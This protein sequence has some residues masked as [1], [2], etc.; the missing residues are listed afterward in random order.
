MASNNHSVERAAAA[1]TGRL[2]EFAAKVARYSV[3]AGSE[4][5]QAKNVSGVRGGGLAF[6]TRSDSLTVFARDEAYGSTREAGSYTG[7]DRLLVSRLRGTLRAAG[8]PLK[9]VASIAIQDEFGREAERIADGRLRLE[10]TRLLTRV[11]VARRALERIP[12]W[13]STAT[14]GLTKRRT[15][16]ELQIHWPE[17]PKVLLREAQLLSEFVAEGWQPPAQ[18]GAWPESLEAGLVHSPAI[19]FFLDMYA[20]IRVVYMAE[21][22]S[23]RRK[24]V[25]HFDRHGDAIP[26]LRSIE[27]PDERQ[28]G[29]REALSQPKSREQ[30]AARRQPRPSRSRTP[31]P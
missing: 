27:G 20:C 23:M 29:P 1:E 19:G 5:G 3:G 7:P 8:V 21:D 30:T 12:V 18:K 2:R 9:E 15:I 22:E 25:M 10:D 16:G 31:G 17:V 26:I 6:S 13:S 28:S 14:L 4:F 24:L 11:A